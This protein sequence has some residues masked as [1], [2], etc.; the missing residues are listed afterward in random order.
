M[1]I[2]NKSVL[3]AWRVAVVLALLT[4]GA[5]TSACA[6]DGVL[7]LGRISD[8]PKSH[9][10]Q[11]KPLLDYVVPRMAD[12]GIRGGRILMASDVQ[13]MHSYL[14]RGRV[15]WVTE[16]AA[17]GMLLAERAPAQLLLIAERNGR[18]RYSTVI[19]AR[20]G[21][22]V[23]D[24][25]T[26]RGRAIAFQ[27]RASASAYMVPAALLLESDYALEMLLSPM[28]QPSEDA[29]GF[30][31]ARTERNIVAWVD[32]GLVAAGAFSDIDWDELQR[33]DGDQAAVL[34]EIARSQP[35]P[36]AVE[37]VRSGL[38]PAVRERLRTVLLQAAQQAEGRAALAGFFGASGF[39]AADA[40][41]LAS[42]QRLRQRAQRVKATLE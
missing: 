33:K 31:F 15:D 8:D 16:T 3:S 4:L 10:A 37:M 28:D 39:H 11:L 9:Y 5:A 32:K 26:L 7:V 40:D 35:F 34:V 12:V 38:S 14:R 23:V 27:N 1:R 21:S 25:A 6:E 19:F 24:L 29:I 36:R 42:L 17:T 22:G 18:S 41:E 2:D 20:R 30:V 13:Q